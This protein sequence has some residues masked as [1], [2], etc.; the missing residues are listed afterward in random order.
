MNLFLFYSIYNM[1]KRLILENWKS[2]KNTDISFEKGY[3]VF[4]GDIGSGKTSIFDGIVFALFGTTPNIN[5]RKILSKDIIM[6]K[7]VQQDS[8][9]VTLEFNV[10]NEEYKIERLVFQDKSSQAK[11]Y[12]GGNL[13]R[14]PKPSDV[15]EEV[16]KI[17]NI[18]MD[19][20]MK[21]NYA[22]QNAIDFFLKLPAG[23]RKQLFDNLFD[24][25]YFDDIAIGARQTSNKL[26]T[27]LEETASTVSEY[28]KL[29]ENY[30]IIQIKNKILEI[31]KNIS[32]LKEEINT[33]QK[34]FVQTKEK[35]TEITKQKTEFEVL[36]STISNL[37][38]KKTYLEKELEKCKDL[39]PV[40]LREIEKQQLSKQKEL[41]T[42]QETKS[43]LES[44]HNE[45]R[46]L[47]LFLTGRIKELEHKK[48][49]FAKIESELKEIPKDIGEITNKIVSE[50]EKIQQQV[51]QNET[52]TD[53][54]EKEIKSIEKLDAQCPLCEQDLPHEHKTKIL[55]TKQSEF[56]LVK[57]KLEKEKTELHKAKK[58]YEI[59]NKQREF[60]NRH[61]EEFS[62]IKKEFEQLGGYKSKL[63]TNLKE[64]K[65]FED[66]LKDILEQGSKIE[67][68]LKEF[69]DKIRAQR[70]KMQKS[71]EHT[72]ATQEI[73]NAESQLKK[74]S[75][76][77]EEYTKLKTSL[78]KIFTELKYKA[79]LQKEKEKQLEEEKFK[80]KQFIALSHNLQKAERKSLLIKQNIEDLDIFGNIAKKTQEQVR[81]LVVQNINFI[82]ADLWKH[83]YP[84]KDFNNI[85]F[86]ISE[87][88]YKIELEFGNN[89][90]RELD[91]FI[92]G[93]ERSA[94]ALALR[95][96]MSLVMKNKLNLIVL[97]EP[98]HN[99]DKTTVLTLSE[100]FNN[101]LPQF[102]DQIFVI[103]HDRVL[104]SYAKNTYHI[105]RN[106]ETD[107]ATEVLGK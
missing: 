44:K 81:E 24:I 39:E 84:Y 99:L 71:E 60:Y 54:L 80:E 79:E 56:V 105:S 90:T 29:L 52:R 68:E 70:D 36:T 74:I 83:I 78:E 48:E 14:G 25:S 55:H 6:A 10:D 8:A 33:K 88:D 19:S 32:L 67:K 22:E 77:P 11:I 61:I 15:T 41:I 12:K 43:K 91:E 47:I 51:T 50:I 26:K 2:H 21:S 5:S 3:N 73:K 35:E 104:E 4:V 27:K 95:I 20:F 76:N 16:E 46:S 38:G 65:E 42:H 1:L 101:H 107:G 100:M 87:G 17:L 9:K 13:I 102:V 7:P 23:E 62:K 93:G 63:A 69:E 28:K 98:T 103:T 66:K 40:D 96:A 58:E 89:Y 18:N 31:E 82:F 106:K 37:N 45:A 57:E 53:R 59:K 64:Q 75:Y 86:S 85:R 49:H 97:D 92:S 94:I 34:Q 30:S 72:K